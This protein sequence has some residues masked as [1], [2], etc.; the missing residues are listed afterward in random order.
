LL[1]ASEHDLV[2]RG[3]TEICR[4]KAKRLPRHMAEQIEVTGSAQAHRNKTRAAGEALARG[5]FNGE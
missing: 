1:L 3:R 2:E 4:K 5:R